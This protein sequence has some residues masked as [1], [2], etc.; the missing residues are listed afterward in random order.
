MWGQFDLLCVAAVANQQQQQQ[1]QQ[2]LANQQLK[3]CKLFKGYNEQ[4]SCFAQLLQTILLLSLKEA[5]PP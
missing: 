3:C 2:Q 4:L 5:T 1:Q